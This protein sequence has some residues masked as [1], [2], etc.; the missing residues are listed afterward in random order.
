MEFNALYAFNNYPL[1]RF[2]SQ[3]ERTGKFDYYLEKT[4]RAAAAAE[5]DDKKQARTAD[6]EL[7]I[8]R[9]LITESEA[10]RKA[11]KQQEA[12]Q[13]RRE[14]RAEACENRIHEIE[15]EIA[16]IQDEMS[17]PENSTDI[18]WMREKSDRTP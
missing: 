13:R 5:T 12:E 16:D 1:G 4:G 17:L 8:T 14:R 15:G 7:E 18:A 6:E 2:A 9:R 10:R 3:L 11:G